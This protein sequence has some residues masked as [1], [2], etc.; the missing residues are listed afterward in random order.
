VTW[1]IETVREAV[2]AT[3]DVF[4]FYADPS[5]WP[6]WGHNATWARAEGPLVQG[7]TVDVRANYGK[8]YRC[9]IRRLEPDRALVLEVRTR[10]LTV[11]QTYEVEDRSGGVRVRHALEL[12]G[13]LSGILRLLGAPWFYQRLLNKEVEELIELAAADRPSGIGNSTSSDASTAF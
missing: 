10:L 1:R 3:A 7:G 8:V 11:T 4:R 5:T 9:L 6:A 2:V 13:W 12:S